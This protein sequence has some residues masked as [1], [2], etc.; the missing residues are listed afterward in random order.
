MIDGRNHILTALRQAAREKQGSEEQPA[1]DPVLAFLTGHPSEPAR[2]QRMFRAKA[3]EVDAT[4]ARLADPGADPRAVPAE[5]QDY[6]SRLG[7]GGPLK[8][9]PHPMIQSLD[10]S[11]CRGP[12]MAEG[13]A[14]ESDRVGLSVAYAGIA[15][16]GTLV[17]L[18]GTESPTSLNFLPEIHIVLLPAGRILDAGEEVWDLMRRERGGT[19]FLPP[20]INWITGP[21]RTADIEQR[22]Q[23][24]V[25]GP[26]H[27]HILILDPEDG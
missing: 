7:P 14:G 20:T 8:L 23:L 11:A 17:L 12:E 27:L 26:R 15:E 16:S 9:A 19:D 4:T 10:W 2:R 6:L 1:P 24:G 22:L 13:A 25:H 5:I 18:S 21:S 3:E